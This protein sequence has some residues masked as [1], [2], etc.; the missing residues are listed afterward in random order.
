[1]SNH[2]AIATVTATLRR[3]LQAAIDND[4]AGATVTT[5]RPDGSGNSTPTKGVNIFLYHVTPNP[6]WR[7]ADLPTR[8]GSGQVVQRPRAALDLHY[9]LTYYG[10]EDKLEPQRLLGS[11]VRAL[12]VQPILTHKTIQE[13]ITDQLF[14]DFLGDSD[15][16]S[17]LELVKFTPS[18]LSLEDLSK[19]WSVFFQ[20][21][22]NLSV[23]YQGT[24]VFIEPEI[25][26][27]T[28][29]PVL[30]PLV[31][32]VTF[33]H[34]LIEQVVAQVAAALTGREKATLEQLI[35]ADSVLLI[36]GRQLSGAKTKVLLAGEANEPTAMTETQITFPLSTITAGKLQAGVQGVQ[37]IQPA[38]L[39]EPPTDHPAAGLES[40]VAA[41]V[42]RP[43]IKVADPTDVTCRQ[44]IE[45]GQPLTVCSG[46][47]TITFDPKVGQRQRIVLLLDE[48]KAT[49][50]DD[51]QLR[52]YSFA[53]PSRE[54]TDPIEEVTIEFTDVVAGDY[55][56]R[57][58]VNGAQSM[59]EQDTDKESETFNRFVNPKVSIT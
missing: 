24:V 26:P 36:K 14:S 52:S 23:G 20:T 22:Y 41:F 42:L 27:R 56:V 48:W 30:K 47:I 54:E 55:L 12:H 57:A 50:Q 28:A 2:L 8:D 25:A 11:V 32:A 53:G 46:K 39:G 37:V 16:A 43:K 51:A 34:L 13:T 19:L 3:L 40:N 21:P 58:Q 4:V 17:E 35:F 38:M 29:L 15:L 33:R 7:N 6:S 31:F 44:V 5:V 45:N 9:L 59:L 49:L 10:N 1:V 18:P